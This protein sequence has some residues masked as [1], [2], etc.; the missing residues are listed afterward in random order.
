MFIYY[1]YV[2][3]HTLITCFHILRLSLPGI[4]RSIIL[5]VPPPFL[6]PP[7]HNTTLVH[8]HQNSHDTI[9]CHFY[10]FGPAFDHFNTP[11][12]GP[13]VLLYR[14]SSHAA[15][16]QKLFLVHRPAMCWRRAQGVGLKARRALR[17]SPRASGLRSRLALAKPAVI[18]EAGPGAGLRKS[19]SRGCQSRLKVRP[20][21]KSC[22]L[23][24]E[25]G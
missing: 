21:S 7:S 22:D 16:A 6:F 3:A 5:K 10:G 20:K 25:P 8:V 4:L 24:L 23:A 12:G 13:R 9:I 19:A 2:N 15:I 14:F 11:P 17:P 1:V 18:G